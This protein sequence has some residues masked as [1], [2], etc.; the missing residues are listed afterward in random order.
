VSDVEYLPDGRSYPD[1]ETGRWVLLFA[2][3]GVEE[4]V[5]TFRELHGTFPEWIV[6]PMSSF[7]RVAGITITSGDCWPI[8]A[9]NVKGHTVKLAWSPPIAG[10][11]FERSAHIGP[12]IEEEE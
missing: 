6:L 12:I 9:C 2:F 4:C 11:A 10:I 5:D 3:P 7:E 8:I 1:V